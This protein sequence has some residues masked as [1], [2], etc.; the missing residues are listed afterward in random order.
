[1][2]IKLSLLAAVT[3]TGGLLAATPA[4]A[5]LITQNIDGNDCSGVFGSFENWCRKPPAQRPVDPVPTMLSFS[6]STTSVIPR[7]ARW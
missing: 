3:L 1:M 7:A 2:N 6:S 4:S 5:V